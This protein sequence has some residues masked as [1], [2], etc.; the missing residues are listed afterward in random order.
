[1]ARPYQLYVDQTYKFVSDVVRGCARVLEVGC[2]RGDVA[3]LLGREGISVT[4]IDLKLVDSRPS[5]GVKFVEA[6]FLR[7]EDAPFDAVIFTSSLHHIHPLQAAIDRAH[8][9][10]APGGTLVAEEFDL[11]APRPLTARWYYDMQELLAAADLY[12][13]ERV[14]PPSNDDPR[15]RWLD[16]HVHT[17]PLATGRQMLT[18]IASRFAI[19]DTTRCPYLFRYLCNGLP[20][21]E[22]GGKIAAHV[23]MT[24]QRRITSAALDAV[25]LR[26]VA[27]SQ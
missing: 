1:M 12:P 26:I 17:P 3:R 2:G 19:R 4:A 23:L 15:M 24:E 6:D 8:R 20:D 18:A 10:L 25:G 13:A 27:M 7:F 22:R 21:D 5:P 16:A 11:D 9:L 14:D